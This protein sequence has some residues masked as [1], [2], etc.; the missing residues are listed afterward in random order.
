M[1]KI[2][3]HPVSNGGELSY[4]ELGGKAS[5][6][7]GS[8]EGSCSYSSPRRE[9]EVLMAQQVSVHQRLEAIKTNL[10]E[11]IEVST[12]TPGVRLSRL[13]SS[14]ERLAR[15]PGRNKDFKKD[16]EHIAVLTAKLSRT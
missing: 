14:I 8:Q 5:K 7:T 9:L 15:Q 12:R 11:Q 1:V 10:S 6:G 3:I 4:I 2:P 16:A 13:Q